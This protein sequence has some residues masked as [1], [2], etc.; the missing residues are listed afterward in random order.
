MKALLLSLYFC[1]KFE[2]FLFVL[3]KKCVCVQYM[4]IHKHYINTLAYAMVWF[5]FE[6]DRL[7]DFYFIRENYTGVQTAQVLHVYVIVC[8][9]L[10]IM[11]MR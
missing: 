8:L 7:L 6:L 2:Y 3:W 10:R 9:C 1:Y 4:Q 5:A 11:L